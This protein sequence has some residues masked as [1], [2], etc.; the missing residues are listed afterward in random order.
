MNSWKCLTRQ[1]FRCG[2]YALV[3]IS[4]EHIEPIRCWRNAQ[5]AVLRQAE[6][7][8]PEQQNAYFARNIWPTMQQSQPANVLVGFLHEGALIGYGGLVHIAWEHRRAEISFLLDTSRT[9]NEVGYARDFTAFLKLIRDVAFDDL[10]LHRL[11]TETYSNRI[12]HIRV[13]EADGFRLEGIM[14]D[15]VYINDAYFDSLIHGIVNSY[16]E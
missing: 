4:P 16:E 5:M 2:P 10:K 7:I 6:V 14:H 9:N 12:N 3:P 1:F 8:S 13:L 11:F 15:H